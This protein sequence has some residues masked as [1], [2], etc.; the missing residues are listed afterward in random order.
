MIKPVTRIVMVLL[1]LAV[2]AFARS[3]S[4]YHNPGVYLGAG[5]LRNKDFFMLTQYDIV[6][7]PESA[8]SPFFLVGFSAVPERNRTVG[9]GCALS[10]AWFALP[11]FAQDISTEITQYSNVRYTLFMTDPHL[12]FR[13]SDRLNL[14]LGFVF[15]LGFNSHDYVSGMYSYNATESKTE[16][17]FM[18]GMGTGLMFL[19]NRRTDIALQYRLIVGTVSSG[20][21]DLYID[22]A[23]MGGAGGGTE[24][25]KLLSLVLRFRI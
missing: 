13:I 4:L 22:G 24:Y 23:N 9:Y 18:G 10:F 16:T 6:K 2:S 11:D 17:N 5:Y 25:M 20:G 8:G 14:D 7:L 21:Y 3:L 19:L 15:A 12:L 1:L